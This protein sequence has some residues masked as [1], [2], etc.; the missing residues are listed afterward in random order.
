MHALV[1]RS[2]HF[3]ESQTQQALA[4]VNHMLAG[5]SRL[6]QIQLCLFLFAIELCSRMLLWKPF[7]KLDQQIQ[8]NL[9]YQF[10]DSNI[11]LIRKGFWGLNT[12]A[13]MAVYGQ[14]SVYGELNYHR[15]ELK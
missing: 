1:P 8:Y 14:T 12:L 6:M 4:L 7:A 9:L 10:F 2:R 3:S 11:P 13:K 5:K 15:R